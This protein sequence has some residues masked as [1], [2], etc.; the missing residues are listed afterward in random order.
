MSLPHLTNISDTALWVAVYRARESRRP[1]AVFHDRFAERLAGRRGEEIVETMRV[2]SLSWPMVVRTAVM[3]EIIVRSVEKEGVDSVL[4][5]A[6]GLDARPYRL[7]LPKTL[8]W[9]EAR[10]AADDRVQGGEP[11]G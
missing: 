6:A 11:A 10:P 3:D 9:I 2:G 4:N 5:L 7:P 1:D 8:R